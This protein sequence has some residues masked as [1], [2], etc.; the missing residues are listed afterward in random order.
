MADLLRA[1]VA[2]A[3]VFG[4]YHANK[5]T[6]V[7]G[8]ALVGVFDLDEA[9]AADGAAA[10][11][12]VGYSDFDAFLAAVDVLTIATPASTHGAL[13]EAAL[14]AG[15]HV[16][17]EK[18]IALDVA[19]ADRLV[20]LAAEKGLTLQVGHQERYVA[21]AMG[22]LDRPAPATLR[23]RRLN[24]FSGRAMDVSVVFDLMI[25]DLDLLGQFSPLDEATVVKTEA[26]F[27]HGE[28]ADYVKVD[29]AFPGGLAASLSAS[30]MEESPVRDL[31]LGYGVGEVGLDFLGRH[32]RNTTD[33]PLAVALDADTKPAALQDPL[34]FGTQSFVDAVRA[35]R[36][37]L[38][39][40][41]DGRA[42]LAL[43][44][45][46]EEAANALRSAS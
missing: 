32:T 18:P 37:P 34:R 11:E 19:V 10:H 9:R 40:G 13:A 30:R 21:G 16:L 6:E 15:K 12:A 22:L 35:G 29:L 5:Y 26:R 31:L 41:A 46:I 24:S 17:V 28:K 44:L 20:A 25:H 43:A 39:T 1:G 3:G 27:V 33:I 7:D 45:K 23:S 42:A 2:G 4:G 14:L 38:V 8:A 36:A